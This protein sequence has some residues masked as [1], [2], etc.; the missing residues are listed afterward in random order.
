MRSRLR[1]LLPTAAL[2][3]VLAVVIALASPYPLPKVTGFQEAETLWAIEDERTESEAPLATGMTCDG[4]TLAYDRDSD[5]YYC[6]LGLEQGDDWPAF[7]LRASGEPGLALCFADDYA[8]DSCREAVR[9]G[10]AYRI[11]T[12]T[13]DAFHYSNIVFTGL[14]TAVLTTNGEAMTREDRPGRLRVTRYGEPEL[15]SDIRLHVRG[16]VSFK[17]EKQSF[18]LDFTRSAAGRKIRRSVPGFGE[19]D[20]MILLAGAHDDSLLR[21]RLGWSL[22]GKIS[23]PAEPLGQRR[24]AY[25]ELFID[26]RYEGIYVMQDPDAP[27]TELAKAGAGA[28]QD[29][30]YRT[31]STFFLS[32]TRPWLAFE[33]R[34]YT[35]FICYYAPTQDAFA[36]LR[37]FLSLE[38][39]ED[40]EAFLRGVSKRIDVD[41]LL[42]YDLFIQTGG[43]TD[44]V[45]NNLYIWAHE[46]AEGPLYR[47]ACWDLD[48][49]YG[50]QNPVNIGSYYE[51]WVCFPLCDRLLNLSPDSR[52]RYA[53]LWRQLQESGYTEE[54]IGRLAE[55][56]AMEL[57]ES[58]AWRRNA[59]RWGLEQELPLWRIQEYLEQRFPVLRQAIS[60]LTEDVAAPVPF[61]AASAYDGGLGVSIYDGFDAPEDAEE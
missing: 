5:T 39:E 6:T 50:N 60:R 54:G 10:Y 20:T 13:E 23:A 12:W 14:P 19:A 53:E 58:G 49:G 16:G 17:S 48:T 51:Y 11:F 32:G 42:L 8:W 46:T 26:G 52:M 4:L 22:W 27:K 34:E 24:T 1:L 31:K 56:L 35:A 40:D 2:A 59:E 43:M 7:D 18:R 3:A 45:Y 44:S 41:S 9:E 37:P 25:C 33:P 30:L 28:L 61:L 55:T 57:T 29:S 38:T 36:A 21:E 15:D 47:F